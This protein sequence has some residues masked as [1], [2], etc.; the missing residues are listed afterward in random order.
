VGFTVDFVRSTKVFTWVL[1]RVQNGFYILLL[2]WFKLM[3]GHGTSM[4][5]NQIGNF[6]ITTNS[7]KDCNGFP[8][9]NPHVKDAPLKSFLPHRC[10][11]LD[12]IQ[13]VK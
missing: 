3:L 12:K 1:L 5:Q 13:N 7:S 8:I 2:K 11:C 10:F 4:T 6:L 9:K